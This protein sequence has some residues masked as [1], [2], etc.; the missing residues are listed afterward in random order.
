MSVISKMSDKD[1]A[2]L[3][4]YLLS[5]FREFARFIHKIL[6]G[7]NMIVVDYLDV[8]FRV[9]QM[10][11]D[12]TSTRMVINIPPRAGKTMLI[13]TYLPL[14][15]WCRNANSHII[16]TGFNSDVLGECSGYIRT[17]MT[18]PDF[19]AV[20]PDV[21]LDNSKRAVEKLG[22]KSAGVLHAI[23][24]TGKMTGKGAGTLAEGFSGFLSI[25]D[26]IKP[27]DAMSPAARTKVNTRFSN[28]LLSRLNSV[29][30]PLVIIM[31]R[32]HPDDL[33]GF[34]L[35]GNTS[36]TYDWLNIPGLITKEAG[37]EEWYNKLIEKNQYKCRPITYDLGRPDEAYDENGYSSFWDRRKSV[38]DL[39]GLKEIDPYTFYS[40]YMGDPRSRGETSLDAEDIARFRLTDEVRASV[41][42]SFVTADTASTSKTYSDYTVLVHWGVT[43]EDN[44]ILIDFLREKMETPKLVREVRGYWK[45]VSKYNSRFPALTPTTMYMEDKSSGLFLNQQFQED[46][47]V[48]VMPV[49]RDGTNSND[50]FTRYL[51]ALPYISAGNVQI[52]AGPEYAPL[53][54][55][56]VGMTEYGNETGHDDFVDNVSDAVV[57]A[58]GEGRIDYSKWA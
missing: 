27:D 3:R 35:R 13:S 51:A 58:F 38:K 20:F 24:T 50:K 45:R 40:Q 30:T 52:P 39:V 56:L 14:F 54:R 29:K 9:A 11:I 34:V 41:V 5:D 37:S 1:R 42:S 43:D 12:Q 32:L 23:P 31:Q 55:E 8:L 6:N 7:S 49:P 16:L 28:T 33:A 2:A 4:K 15:A 53:V 19:K 17:I 46:G 47:T 21:V 10:L 48:P 44:L 26:A 36:D 22:T 25:D 18:D 57:V